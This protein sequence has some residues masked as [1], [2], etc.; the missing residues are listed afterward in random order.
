MAAEGVTKESRPS[1]APAVPSTERVSQGVTIPAPWLDR[2]L[3]VQCGVR[4]DAPLE[5]DVTHILDVARE[6]LEDVSVGV[7]IP[8]LHPAVSSAPPAAPARV[9]LSA[10][11]D[12]AAGGPKPRVGFAD[13]ET[14]YP[15]AIPAP[16]RQPGDRQMLIRLASTRTSRPVEPDPTR[17]FPEMGSERVISILGVEGATLHV[18]SDDEARIAEGAP[19][20]LLL[21]RVAAMIGAAVEQHRAV[22]RAL[23]ELRAQVIQSEKLASLGQIAAGIVHELNNPLTTIV[24]YSDFL[25]KKLE[26]KG[27]DPSDV[28]R[29]A[30]I[31][32][33]AERILRFSRDLT[34]YSRPSSEVPAPV[35]IHDIIERALVF[36]EHEL[37]KTGVMVE[38]HF[39][40]VRPVRGVAGQLTQVFVNLFTNAAHAMREEGGLLT[41]STTMQADEVTIVITDDGHGI[42]AEHRERIFEPF[43]TTKTDGTGTGLGLSIVRSIVQN[44]GGRISV[45]GND[46]RGTV[47]HLELPTAAAPKSDH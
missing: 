13:P 43:F 27:G 22:D 17:I 3:A 16:P 33:A 11:Y 39:G 30:R 23:A 2:L 38:R 4:A 12:G 45:D 29:L 18:A 15:S 35:P 47:F 19:A 5:D 42:D 21:D 26:R 9:T 7:C 8:Q 1:D 41:I 31:N 24:A 44:H 32:E 14:G 6:L 46:P 20:A 37:D 28:E 40:D 34:A 36:C 25:R 10:G